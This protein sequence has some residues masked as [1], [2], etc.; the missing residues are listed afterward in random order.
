M[1]LHVLIIP[2]KFKG[3]LTAAAAAEAVARGW[4]KARPE[5]SLDLLPMS[6]GGDGFGEVTSAL[7]KARVQH[8]KTVDAAH[9]PC[10]TRWWWEPRTQTA[11]I[12]SAAVVGLA[13]LPPQRLH[14]FQLVTLALGAVVRAAA[15]RGARRCLMGI[16]GS[17][18]NDGGF[19]LARALGWEFLDRQG[20]VIEGWTGLARIFHRGIEQRSGE[21]VRRLEIT[22]P[23]EIATHRFFNDRL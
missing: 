13:M 16:G 21:R 4:R 12:E 3:T 23:N 8:V 22:Q 2:D 7:L 9:R 10:V 5:D 17:A 18:T 6:D 1:P 14:P 19:G 15:K 11:I 20:E